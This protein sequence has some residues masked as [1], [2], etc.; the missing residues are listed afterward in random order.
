[1]PGEP[2][3][4]PSPAGA[5]IWPSVAPFGEAGQISASIIVLA[6]LC[7]SA[8][9]TFASKGGRNHTWPPTAQTTGL[10]RVSAPGIAARSPEPGI[11][12]GRL[13]GAD[14]LGHRAVRAAEMLPAHA[15]GMLD[16][17]DELHLGGKHRRAGGVEVADPEACHV[18]SLPGDGDADDVPEQ[19]DRLGVPVVADG[20]RAGAGRSILT[21][22]GSCSSWV[23]N[24]VAF[25]LPQ[26]VTRG[27]SGRT[28][29]VIGGL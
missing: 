1:M 21:R 2:G 25:T 29:G 13:P 8:G 9:S 4:A 14:D 16:R 6:F 23:P 24:G 28:L 22:S 18:H 5:E 27:S 11:R 15:V 19:A 17:A 12:C 3:P 20:A 7:S 26:P 10:D